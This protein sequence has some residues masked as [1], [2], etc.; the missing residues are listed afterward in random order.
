MPILRRI[1]LS[2]MTL[3]TNRW[4][5]VKVEL[6]EDE[7]CPIRNVVPF[8]IGMEYVDDVWIHKIWEA[9]LVVFRRE[10]KDYDG[11]VVRYFAEYNSNINVV[12][13]VFFH[14]E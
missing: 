14:L 11:T 2:L 9:L 6:L 8:V 3:K 1:P 12:G 5:A 7:L 4:D 10:I 13:R